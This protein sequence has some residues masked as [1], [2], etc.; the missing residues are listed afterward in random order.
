MAPTVCPLVGS[1]FAH[2]V[3]FLPLGSAVGASLQVPLFL[4]LSRP[5]PCFQ[6]PCAYWAA[7]SNLGS[8]GVALLPALEPS[9]PGPSSSV[10]PS[11]TSR[12]QGG[13]P[14]GGHRGA[15]ARMRAWRLS[16]IPHPGHMFVLVGRPKILEQWGPSPQCPVTCQAG[17]PVGTVLLSVSP[18]HV[19]YWL[20]H[21]LLQD[22]F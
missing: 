14:T 18:A 5:L 6:A 16:P 22:T 19:F 3:P 8:Q 12:V 4:K 15:R 9:D 17:L 20:Y 7:G 2:W 11:P 1:C 13:S 21:L 10:H